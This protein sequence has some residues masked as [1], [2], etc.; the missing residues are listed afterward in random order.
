MHRP[1]FLEP[2]FSTPFYSSAM[3]KGVCLGAARETISLVDKILATDHLEAN[4]WSPFYH[5]VMAATL[6]VLISLSDETFEENASLLEFCSRSLDTLRRM[7]PSCPKKGISLIETLLAQ[8]QI[9]I[10]DARNPNKV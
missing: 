1:F 9:K 3:A 6:V 7:E 10:Q 5:R 8:Q 2:K 4:Q